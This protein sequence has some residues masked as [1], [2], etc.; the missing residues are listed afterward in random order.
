MFDMVKNAGDNAGYQLRITYNA[1]NKT[2]HLSGFV[3]F[4]DNN[5]RIEYDR[6]GA[7]LFFN[8]LDEVIA[9]ITNYGA[10]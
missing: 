1:E 4:K 10:K 8:S 6:D 2:Y 9:H 3:V 7:T 5:N